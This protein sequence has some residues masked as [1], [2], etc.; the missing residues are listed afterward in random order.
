MGHSAAND[1][2]GVLG[3][4][5]GRGTNSDSRSDRG[6]LPLNDRSDRGTLDSG[7]RYHRE[8]SN[9][10]YGT[11]ARF[12]SVRLFIDHAVSLNQCY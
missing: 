1:A 5:L 3:D 8:N 6:R 2:S 11:G 12:D 9:S 7:E 10:I 4:V